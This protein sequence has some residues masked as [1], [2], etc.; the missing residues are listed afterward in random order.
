MDCHAAAFDMFDGIDRFAEAQT[1]A[2]VAQVV[3]KLVDDFAVE[4]AEDFCP[5]IDDGDVDVECIQHRGVFHAD[6]PGTDDDK[7]VRQ[8]FHLQQVIA[9]NDVY[10]VE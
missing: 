3:D 4:E 7:R 9:V 5:A 8:R 2:A 1:H 6:D 10:R